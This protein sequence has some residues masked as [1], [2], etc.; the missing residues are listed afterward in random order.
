M[1]YAIANQFYLVDVLISVLSLISW[2]YAIFMTTLTV[3]L[4]KMLNLLLFTIAISCSYYNIHYKNK[5][6]VATAFVVLPVA[7]PDDQLV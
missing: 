7:S 5:T 2:S 6:S 3:K 4:V 1:A